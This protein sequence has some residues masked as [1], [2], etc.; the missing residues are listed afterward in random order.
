MKPEL[1]E[2]E[3]GCCPSCGAMLVDEEAARP[4]CWRCA[5]RLER[6]LATYLEFVAVSREPA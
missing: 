6:E 1:E 3:E 4:V 2:F 5:A